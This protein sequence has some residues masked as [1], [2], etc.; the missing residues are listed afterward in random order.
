M[1]KH[2]RWHSADIKRARKDKLRQEKKR[3][4]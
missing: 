3:A 2:K 4:Q 1:A